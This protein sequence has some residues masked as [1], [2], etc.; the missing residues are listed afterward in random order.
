[1]NVVIIDDERLARDEL[2]RLLKNHAEVNIVGEA[3]NVVEAR[4]AIET[5]APD[6]IFLDIR[7]PGGNGFELL[8]SLEEAP[9]VI[10]TTAF[11]SYAIRAF[12]VNALDYLQKPVDPQRLESALLRCAR[13]LHPRVAAPQ[14]QAGE[15]KVFIKDGER[16]WFVAL[17]QI[18]LFESEGNYTRVFFDNERPLLLRSLNQ[19]ELRLDP[20]HFVRVSRRYIAN[21]QFV[22]G[23]APSAAGGLTLTLKGELSIEMSR[24]R[25]VEFKLSNRL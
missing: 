12:Q 11:D 19:L 23:I 24:R 10:F 9:A 21:L 8:E 22:T 17:D 18:A 14:V 16:C 5:L 6:L 15:S 7:M 4:H 25:A 1:M 2:R 20:A 3:T 13:Q